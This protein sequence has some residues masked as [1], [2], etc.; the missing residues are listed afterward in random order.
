LEYIG[1]S[2]ED[3]SS[4]T[5]QIADLP[6]NQLGE[7]I[8]RT[9]FLDWN[10]AGHGWFIDPSPADDIEF[11]TSHIETMEKVDLL[12]VIAHEL[13]H[14]L[15]LEHHENDTHFMVEQLSLGIRHR[16][17]E[18]DLATLDFLSNADML[19]ELLV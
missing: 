3:L 15:G 16:I 4:V 6:G 19:S 10:A 12:T 13:G 18:N 17:E 5:I 11:Q 1:L 2:G 8:G 7:A 14:V 9:I